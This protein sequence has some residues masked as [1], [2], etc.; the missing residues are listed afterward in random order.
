MDQRN[1]NDHSRGPLGS[2]WDTYRD[3]QLAL[4]D[5][6]GVR[7]CLLV[8]SCIGPS[9]ALS[10]MAHA[11]TRFPAAVLLQPIGLAMHTTEPCEPWEGL[12]GGTRK[13]FAK[14]AAAMVAAGRFARSDMD[15][16]HEAMYGSGRDFV[17][18]VGQEAVAVLQ[19][20]LL[21]FMGRDRSHPSE[22]AREI[23]RLAPCATLVE[24]WRDEDSTPEV[25]RRIEAFLV[26]HGAAMQ[27]GAQAL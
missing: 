11:P 16:L 22:T 9:Y 27:E 1:A 19:Q 14:W 2:G 10:L 15:A 24:R 4:L 6:L 23:A 21:V 25:G 3:D 20:P 5:H 7:C 26:E 12:S 13:S 18:S 17:F 8:G